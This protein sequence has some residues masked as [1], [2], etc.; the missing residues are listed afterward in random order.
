MGASYQFF[1]KYRSFR[2]FWHSI[3]HEN[4]INQRKIDDE[5]RLNSV[6]LK[7]NKYLCFLQ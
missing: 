2:A 1:M 7:K 6:I 4:S 3:K 5:K